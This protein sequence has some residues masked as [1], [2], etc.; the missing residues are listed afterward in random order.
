M[1]PTPD[2][3]SLARFEAERAAG[4]RIGVALSGGSDSTALLTL[5]TDAFGPHALF[6]VTV[7]HRL[8]DAS[9]DEAER[10][11]A[12]C[13]VM[14]TAHE[15]VT[16][17]GWDGR[18]NMQGRAREARYRL[19]ARWAAQSGIRA[20][21]LGHT[22]DDV[23]ETSLM[24]L[25]RSA[26]LDGLS[27]MRR[28]FDR[29]DTTFL[30]PLLHVARA[31]LRAVLEKRGIGW[32]DDP[33]NA[34]PRFER[35]RV[36]RALD[37]LAPCGITAGRIA[38]SARHL[39]EDRQA[40]RDHL[41]EWAGHHSRQ[42]SGDLVLKRAAF[43]ALPPSFGRRIL[44]AGLVWV[45]G[46]EYAPRSAPVAALLETGSGT[47]AGCLVTADAQQWRIAREPAAVYR[48]EDAALEAVWDGRWRID[49]PALAGARI[50]ALGEK[51]LARLSAD[52]RG[53]LPAGTLAAGPALWQGA[54]LV[55]APLASAGP[56]RAR[57]VEGRDDFAAAIPSY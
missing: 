36:R 47:L 19:I 42:V 31:D 14:G 28:Q 43:D 46:A 29:E 5:L 38:A 23:A 52:Q 30:R 9:H 37:L 50:A 55:A 26:G 25:A 45:S 44:S 18:G 10:V 54:R 13:A 17:T 51:G 2:A 35:V 22:R 34:D 40:I 57:L 16:W 7:D 24:G 33:S 56:W 32:I 53:S 3:A 12:F 41:R 4:R 1:T 49:G 15:V 39:S 6:A 20:V 21:A 27:A 8:R 48:S 11:G